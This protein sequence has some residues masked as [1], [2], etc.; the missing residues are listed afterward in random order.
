MSIRLITEVARMAHFFKNMFIRPTEEELKTFKSDWTI[1]NACKTTFAD[2]EK[3]DMRSEVFAAFNKI[4][5]PKS[6]E[7][8]PD[9]GHENLP[10]HPEKI[11]SF[12]TG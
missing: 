11:F 5:A 2:F 6:Y 4:T 1:L 3:F 10:M 7:I 8:Y 12:I 9:F